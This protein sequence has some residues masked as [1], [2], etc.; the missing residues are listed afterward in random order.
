VTDR[1]RLVDAVRTAG[2]SVTRI[3][4]ERAENVRLH[5][6]LNAAVAAAMR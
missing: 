4:T 3:V 1:A 6:E 2:P 5:A